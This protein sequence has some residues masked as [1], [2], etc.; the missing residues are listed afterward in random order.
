MKISELIATLTRLQ[1]EEGA[2]LEV[3]VENMNIAQLHVMESFRSGK[4]IVIEIED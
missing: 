3:M 1:A 4:V 2:D